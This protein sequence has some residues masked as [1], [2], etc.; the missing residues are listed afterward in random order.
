MK[1]L[2]LF[3]I[4]VSLH[5]NAQDYLVRQYLDRS[6]VEL[7]ESFERGSS[8][9]VNEGDTFF[10][11]CK[12][13]TKGANPSGMSI[14][15]VSFI[16]RHEASLQFFDSNYQLANSKVVALENIKKD[17]KNFFI[18]FPNSSTISLCHSSH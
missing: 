11:T 12:M 2:V 13:Y 6:F 9:D 14:L 7:Q 8:L 15:E 10:L 17:G 16:N 3:F 1:H 4:L 18:S 5:S